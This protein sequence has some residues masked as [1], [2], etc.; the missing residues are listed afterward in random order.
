M[1]RYVVLLG[2]GTSASIRRRLRVDDVI[3]WAAAL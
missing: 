1:P 3:A 2:L